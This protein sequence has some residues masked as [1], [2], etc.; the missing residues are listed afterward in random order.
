MLLHD[1]DNMSYGAMLVIRTDENGVRRWEHGG[2]L[3]D[4]H[5]KD[6][7]EADPRGYRTAVRFPSGETRTYDDFS[8]DIDEDGA[9]ELTGH[10]NDSTF[11]GLIGITGE[12]ELTGVLD[13][14]YVDEVRD[15]Y[16]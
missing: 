15:E 8:L 5:L 12:E 16:G 7:Y 9:I 6:G 14:E 10:R 3:H 11:L 1:N 13:P 4:G 2:S